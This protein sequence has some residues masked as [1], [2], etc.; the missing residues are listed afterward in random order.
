MA[1]ERCI[2]AFRIQESHVKKITTE[3]GLPAHTDR[4]PATRERGTAEGNHRLREEL[5]KMEAEKI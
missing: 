4:R 2:D 1:N 5:A 3:A